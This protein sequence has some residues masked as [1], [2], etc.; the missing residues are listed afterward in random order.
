MD[1]KIKKELGQQEQSEFHRRMVTECR[2]LLKP[3]RESMSQYYNDWD[4]FE[5]VYK[6]ERRRD[7]EDLKARER[8]EPE[9][10]VVPMS[11]AQVQTFVAFC[12]S[13][14]TQRPLMFELTGSGVEDWKAAK[15]AEAV[16][17]RDLTYNKF[18]ITLYQFLL[19]IGR[20][21]IGIIKHGW[22]RETQQQWVQPTAPEQQ[23]VPVTPSLDGTSIDFG[24][25][26]TLGPELQETVKYLGNRIEPISPY[27]FFPDPRVPLSRFQ[28]GEFCASE[29]DVTHNWL[30]KM[31]H[32]GLYAGTKYVKDMTGSLWEERQSLGMR[33]KVLYDAVSGKQKGGVILTEIQREIIPS[34]YTLP[35]G[36]KL[37]DEDYPVKYVIVIANDD[38][39]IKCEPLNYLHDHYTYSC[40]Q[41]SP[42]QHRTINGGVSDLINELQSIMTWLINTRITSVRKTLQNQ[43]VVDPEGVEMSD[44]ANR[45]PVIRLKKGMGRSGVDRWIK[46]L[47]VQDVTAGHIDDANQLGSI[48]QIITGINDNALGQYSSGR[49]SA[50][51]TQ[52]VNSGAATR[53]KMWASL[54]WV[55]GV[56]SLGEDCL[57][58]LRDGLDESQLVKVMGLQTVAPISPYAVGQNDFVQFLQVDKSQLIGNYDFKTLDGTLPTE[59]S[60]VANMLQELLTACLTNPQAA[61]ILGLDPKALLTEIA[62]LNSIRNPERFF[63]GAVQQ[64]A[65][66]EMATQAQAN[67]S[68][69]PLTQTAGAAAASAAATSQ[70]AALPLQ[71]ELQGTPPPAPT[72]QPSFTAGLPSL[73]Q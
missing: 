48:M 7:S 59:K 24:G 36:D 5:Q 1:D 56:Q 54:I 13:L 31:E 68:A 62:E 12:F 28:E 3:S 44:L 70:Q 52:A 72:A 14:Y 2:E 11:Y 46:Q 9:K 17:D 16:L 37:G 69:T 45:L 26:E 29:V 34:E 65:M 18:E 22:V 25:P 41:L 39:V 43:I 42:D 8:K 53:L 50:Q 4:L 40:A 58:N 73:P 23:P 51:Q 35:N 47:D 55:Q 63:L 60:Q 66:M 33:S 27:R 49:R 38:R 64:Q 30:R 15:I 57:S 6:G 32:N 20:F 67:G 71:P 61:A 10:M 21:G 19:D